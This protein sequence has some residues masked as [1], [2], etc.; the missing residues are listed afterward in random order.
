MRKYLDEFL[1][2][3]KNKQASK[4]LHK[5]L[6]TP[7]FKWLNEN[8]LG[9]EEFTYKDFQNYLEIAPVDK[10]TKEYNKSTLEQIKNCLLR[11]L[12]WY[13]RQKVPDDNTAEKIKHNERINRIVKDLVVP[14]H[15]GY[16]YR[17]GGE[18]KALKG[19]ELER[20]LNKAKMRTKK[21][22][23]LFYIF[24]YTGMRSSELSPDMFLEVDRQARRLKFETSKHEDKP[25]V[26][27]FTEKAWTIF[28]ELMQNRIIESTTNER[29]RL[30]KKHYRSLMPDE[31][32]L[33]THSFRHTFRTHMKNQTGD[34]PLVKM[35]MGHFSGDVSDGYDETFNE[36]IKEAM[37]EE[38]YYNGLDIPF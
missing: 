2:S 31:V 25:R 12:R 18:R 28:E 1:S 24:G 38:H 20:L 4:T 30:L 6:L 19:G 8:E 36:E 33:T 21:D 16:M 23:L 22:F 27:F 5:S 7:F 14:D 11:F 35:L 10:P 32:E 37:T 17:E 26:L 3:Y 29:N 13:R 9:I 15:T 34:K